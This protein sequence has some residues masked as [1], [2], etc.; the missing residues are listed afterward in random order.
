MKALEEQALEDCKAYLDYEG[1]PIAYA[2]T[3]AGAHVRLWGCWPDKA[4]ME[5]FWGPYAAGDWHQFKDIRDDLAAVE[6]EA[7]FVR[8][9]RFPPAPHAGQTND[10]CG[11]LYQPGTSRYPTVVGNHAITSSY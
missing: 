9:K 4:E 8:M 2:A 3:M 6:I 5:P 11:S 7:G 10:T 1:I